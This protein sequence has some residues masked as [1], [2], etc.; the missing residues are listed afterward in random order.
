MLQATDV[1]VHFPVR[2]GLLRRTKSWIKAVDGVDLSVMAGRTLGIVG[3]SGSGKSTLAR[4]LAQLVPSHG[5]ITLDNR[6][7]SQRDTNGLRAFRRQVQIVFQDPFGSLSPRISVGEII[8]EG[9][10]AHGIGTVE[11]RQREVAQVL[12]EVG[13]DPSVA[14]NY[15]HEFSG[16]QRQRIA[17]A[18][19]LVMKPRI[20]LFDE[21]TSA[22]DMTV[23]K[24]LIALLQDLQD[25]LGIGYLFISHDI[26]LIGSISHDIMVMKDGVVVERG[27]AGQI[28]TDPQHPYTVNLIKAARR[29][30]A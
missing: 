19:A 4:A 27:T 13:L 1:K 8:A 9:L 30:S 15:P 20:I 25:R 3:E 23:Q 6:E 5:R 7:I 16:G 18:R 22:L 26:A 11:D 2:G 21:P 29:K 24:S 12:T 10:A 28:M 14:G 17:I